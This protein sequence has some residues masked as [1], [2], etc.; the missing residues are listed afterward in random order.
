[1]LQVLEAVLVIAHHSQQ[2]QMVCL[3]ILLVLQVF[4]FVLVFAKTL[5]YQHQ[6]SISQHY[7]QN[8]RI[9]DIVSLYFP[10]Q[11]ATQIK[12]NQYGITLQLQLITIA[13]ETAQPYQIIAQFQHYGGK[14]C[15]TNI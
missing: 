5:H 10:Q 7:K 6:Y 11:T 12:F 15:D 8:N 3:G 13:S 14:Q 4:I 9:W 2:Y 1:M